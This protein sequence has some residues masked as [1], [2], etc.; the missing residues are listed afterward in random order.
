MA[1]MLIFT[2]SGWASYDKAL[3]LFQKKQYAESLK[4]CADDLVIADDFKENSPNYNLRYLAAHSHWKLGN[5]EPVIQHFRR[6]MDIRKDEVNPYIDLA[7]FFMEI[8]RM[9]DAESTA[10]SGLRIKQNPMLYYVVGKVSLLKSNYWRAKE[11]F[12]KANAMTQEFYFSYNS[13]GIALMN[14]SKFSEANTA[15]T[16][17]SALYP[18][19]P[20]ILNN[21]GMSYEMLLKHDRARECL[22]K[23]QLLDKGSRTIQD[24]LQRIKGRSAK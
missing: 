10:Q 21:L 24:N 19:S 15:F 17:A 9:G 22:E 16:I 4:V 12:E 11:Y 7:L 8:D 2:G 23:A 20:Q 3:E 18:D 5:R 6:C 13:L 14:L 1:V